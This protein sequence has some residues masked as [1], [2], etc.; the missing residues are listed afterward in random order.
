MGLIG[1][2]V[3]EITA[4]AK[5]ATSASASTKAASSAEASSA[6]AVS[7]GATS[8]GSARATGT[9]GVTGDGCVAF[10]RARWA[11]AEVDAGKG[12]GRAIL[13]GDGDGFGGDI[14]V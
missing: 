5:A 14:R 13:A 11:I 4:S 12:V 2:E 9:T 8:A 7:T 1:I 3:A 10:P 6:R